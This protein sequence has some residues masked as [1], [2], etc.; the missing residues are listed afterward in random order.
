MRFF[1]G[2]RV[3]ILN[4]PFSLPQLL[5]NLG[6]AVANERGSSSVIFFSKDVSTC[7]IGDVVKPTVAVSTGGHYSHLI[8]Q[9]P[10]LNLHQ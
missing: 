10:L 5:L 8:K 1:S 9:M 4:F 7:A 6:A 2:D 3:R